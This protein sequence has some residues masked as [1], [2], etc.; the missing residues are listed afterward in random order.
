MMHAELSVFTSPDTLGGLGCVCL[1]LRSVHM[2][3]FSHRLTEF[4]LVGQNDT[5]ISKDIISIQLV[6]IVP[7]TA[8]TAITR[9]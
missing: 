9:P 5:N 6:S 7:L 4:V 2:R 3:M 8:N 1:C